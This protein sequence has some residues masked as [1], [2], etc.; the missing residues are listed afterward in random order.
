MNL[1]KIKDCEGYQRD[2]RTGAIVSTDNSG[3][4]AYKKQREGRRALESRLD[5][6]EAQ[7]KVIID[8]INRS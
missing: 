4:Q 1:Q 3:L 8:A 2:E 6:I 5:N 7:L